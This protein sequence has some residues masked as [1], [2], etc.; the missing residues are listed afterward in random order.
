MA[1]TIQIDRFRVDTAQMAAT[2]EE[3]RQQGNDMKRH[4]DEIS[5]VMDRTGTYWTGEAADRHRKLYSEQKDDVDQMLRRIMEHPVDLGL[6]S[7]QYREGENQSVSIA[8][9]LP[10]DTIS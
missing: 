7:Q 8:E 9:G 10:S 5:A 2:A 6:I 3:L 4:F 1:A